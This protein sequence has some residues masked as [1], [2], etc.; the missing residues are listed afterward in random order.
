MLI[1]TTND[2]LWPWVRGHNMSTG[3]CYGE[4]NPRRGRGWIKYMGNRNDNLFIIQTVSYS[5]LQATLT[6]PDQPPAAA[7]FHNLPVCRFTH[8]H[9]LF[10]AILQFLAAT[11]YNTTTTTIASCVT[12]A[13]S[14]IPSPYP[15]I[16]SPGER[17]CSVQRHSLIHLILHC[18][19]E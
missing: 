8:T 16:T 4:V 11:K 6:E 14:F 9:K 18:T 1:S 15:L 3:T 5:R 12:R 13:F 7:H 10:F 17:I 19:S 2:L